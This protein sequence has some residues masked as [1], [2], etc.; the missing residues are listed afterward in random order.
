[1]QVI[2]EFVDNC[3]NK[4]PNKNILIKNYQIFM[5]CHFSDSKLYLKEGEKDW[6]EFLTPEN[7]T[8]LQEHEYYIIGYMVINEA[9]SD[10]I[11]YIDF[12][13]IRLRGYN[14]AS[15]MMYKYVDRFLETEV[16]RVEGS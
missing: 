9:K 14:L 5:F 10:N 16:S 7:Y 12:I 6:N 11:H 8:F 2:K 15:F 3:I 13:D 1:M 4:H